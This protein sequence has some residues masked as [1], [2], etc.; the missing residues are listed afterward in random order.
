MSG[1]LWSRPR[2][3]PDPGAPSS[4]LNKHYPFH[5]SSKAPMFPV[6]RLEDSPILAVQNSSMEANGAKQ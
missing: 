3:Q 2:A 4:N 5:P 6:H 1:P